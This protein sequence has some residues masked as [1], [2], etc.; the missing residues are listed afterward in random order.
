MKY[1]VVEY[2]GLVERWI[3]WGSRPDGSGRVVKAFKTRKGA[4]NWVRKHS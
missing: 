4:E 2:P 1:E 3:V